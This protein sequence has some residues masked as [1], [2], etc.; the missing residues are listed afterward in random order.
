MQK[1]SKEK[2]IDILLVTDLIK[3]AF[4]NKYEIALLV[5]GDAD[6]VPA[7]ELA[8]TLNKEIINVHCYAGS[9]SELRNICDSHIQIDVDGKY[10]CIL[11]YY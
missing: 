1:L 9:S 8:Q 6:F 3:G 10:K 11:K 5:T 2:G 7:V 4:Q